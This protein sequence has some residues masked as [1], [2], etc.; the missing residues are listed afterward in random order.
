MQASDDIIFIITTM[1]GIPVIKGDG[2]IMQFS[3]T[4][5]C[6]NNAKHR[7]YNEKTRH[8]SRGLTRKQFFA[9]KKEYMTEGVISMASL[10]W[11]GDHN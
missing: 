3:D 10:G 11:K 1:D 2:T 6:R 9:A 7:T 8:H 4:T 5:S